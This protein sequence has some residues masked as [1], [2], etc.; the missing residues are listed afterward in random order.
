[1]QLG[2]TVSM[3][4]VNGLQIITVNMEESV[5]PDK[6]QFRKL[7]G[8]IEQAIVEMSNSI[9]N[10]HSKPIESDDLRR[11]RHIFA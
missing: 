11:R 2:A 6:A 5:F 3:G 10:V 9:E 8:Y 4:G 7:S 1:M